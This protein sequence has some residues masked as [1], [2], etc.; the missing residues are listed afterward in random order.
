MAFVQQSPLPFTRAGIQWL[1]P[2]QMGVYGIFRDG[3]WVY[4]G[5]GDI[6]QRLLDHLNGD[7]PAI[8]AQRPSHYVAEVTPYYILREKELIQECRPVCNQRVG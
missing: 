8:V 6:R 7:N 3:T 1:N 4:V 2:G 5:S